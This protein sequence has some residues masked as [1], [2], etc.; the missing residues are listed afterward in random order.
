LVF[1]QAARGR[2]IAANTAVNYPDPLLSALTEGCIASGLD[3]S[4]GARYETETVELMGFANTAN[5]IAIIDTLVFRQKKYTL[6]Q[7]MEAARQDFQNC[8]DLLRDMRA[9]PK[10]GTN[11]P[12]ADAIAS[13]ICDVADKVCR[14]E[15]SGNVYF[16]PSLHTIHENVRVGGNMTATLDGRRKGEPVSKNAG[17]TNDVRSVDPTSLILSAASLR[18]ERFS[19]GQPIDLYF[20]RSMLDSKEKRDKIKA[21]IKTYFQLGGLQLQVNSIDL[22]M[23]EAAFDKPEDYPHI[24]VRLGGYSVRFSSLNKAVQAEFIERFRKERGL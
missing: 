22:A 14:E 10:Y 9:C 13:R 11:H 7:L 2:K 16:L 8:D 19:G 1:I 20:D 5:A 6:E 4:V 3:R 18:Q 23:L 21:L 24:I 17:P 15:S 12:A